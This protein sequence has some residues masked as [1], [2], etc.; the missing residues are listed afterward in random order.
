MADSATLV[1]AL[2]LLGVLS[3]A[4]SKGTAVKVEV[5]LPGLTARIEVREETKG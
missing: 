5:R 2:R 1:V 4:I 3:L